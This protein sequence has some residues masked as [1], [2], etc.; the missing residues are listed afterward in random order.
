TSTY[1]KNDFDILGLYTSYSGGH[2]KWGWTGGI[3]YEYTWLDTKFKDPAMNFKSN[4]VVGVPSAMLTYKISPMETFKLG[5]NM[6]IQRPSISFLNPYVDRRDPN[7][8][9]FGNPKLDPEKSHNITFGYSKFAQA[10][11][12]SSELTYT[13]V[14][15]SIQQY[16]L[17]E[18][19]TTVQK[20]TY[21]NIGH[22]KQV[23]LNVFGSYRG[24][25]WLNLY[26]NSS[27]TYVKM[28]SSDY[29][30]S[31]S[32]F[33][34][35][36][37]LGGTVTMPKDMR[38]ST[39]GGGSL[40]Q[41]NLQGSQSSFFFSYVALSKDF[42][43]KR[44]SVSVSG[45]YLPKSHIIIDT[46]GTDFKTHKPTFNQRTDVHLT[47]TTEFRLN[48]SYRIGS[49]TAK[50]KKAKATITNDDQKEK[51]NNSVGQSPVM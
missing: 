8:I 51:E 48:I 34:G 42:F 46:K 6:R 33:T 24:L 35:R 7:Y 47:K 16:S 31:N 9:S 15:N 49:I 5:Y 25:P 44:L 40:P 37:Y 4:Y 50:V 45:V 17:I 14:N 43:Q 12:L 23:N 26:T 18:T 22:N 21:D 39:G 10:F 41:V 13:F 11:N 27:I 2:A 20:I 32:G 29:G 36:F 38:I 19:G 1:F 30:I 28:K 3:R